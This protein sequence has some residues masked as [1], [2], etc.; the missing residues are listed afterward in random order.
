M[1]KVLLGYLEIRW[2]AD[3][4]LLSEIKENALNAFGAC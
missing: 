1:L 3:L 2:A 4:P